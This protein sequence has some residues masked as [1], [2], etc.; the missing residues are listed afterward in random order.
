MNNRGTTQ[1]Y[2]IRDFAAD[3]ALSLK[4]LTVSDL[5]D[6]AIRARALRDLTAVWDIC[7][8]QIRIARGK[9]LP[10]AVEASNA[11][12]KVKREWPTP[13]QAPAKPVAQAEP[14]P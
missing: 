5:Q 12:R 7:R 14:K 3:S 11:R 10:K 4:S 1:A 6:H 8:E 2:D 13:E 9:G